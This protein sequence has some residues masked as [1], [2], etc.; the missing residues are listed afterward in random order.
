[1]SVSSLKIAHKPSIN[2]SGYRRSGHLGIHSWAAY[3]N[4]SQLTYHLDRCHRKVAA[5]LLVVGVLEE[6][7]IPG[8]AY[9]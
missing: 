5:Q 9:F 8:F 1:L 3:F 6:A 7:A 2:R 4:L